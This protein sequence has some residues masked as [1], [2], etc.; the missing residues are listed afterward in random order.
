MR[1]NNALTV[2]DVDNIVRRNFAPDIKKLAS[3]IENKFGDPVALRAIGARI[4]ASYG[5]EGLRK[6]INR[7]QIIYGGDY[8]DRELLD[9]IYQDAC[10][11]RKKTTKAEAVARHIDALVELL[12]DEP[13]DIVEP[14]LDDLLERIDSARKLLEQL[15]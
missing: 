2:T 9:G 7:L 6:A 11:K 5:Q 4:V 13:N 12:Q 10:T 1:K 15:K 3:E 14:V 8:S